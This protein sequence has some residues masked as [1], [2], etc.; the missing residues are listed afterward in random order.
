MRQQSGFC[1]ESE[2]ILTRLRRHVS[3]FRQQCRIGSGLQD[4][5]IQISK[6]NGLPHAKSESKRRAEL[7]TNSPE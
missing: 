1:P 7:K 4:A 2:F 3:V 6:Q 5:E